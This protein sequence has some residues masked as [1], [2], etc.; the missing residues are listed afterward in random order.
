MSARIDIFRALKARYPV[1]FVATAEE[2]RLLDDLKAVWPG[3]VHS[4]TVTRGL[5]EKETSGPGSTV[6]GPDPILA[7]IHAA[8]AADTVFVLHD[9]HVFLSNPV[10]ARTL[11]DLCESTVRNDLGEPIP[12]LGGLGGRKVH[13]VVTCPGFDRVPAEVRC[14]EGIAF[15]SYNR[16]DREQL[17]GLAQLAL[18]NV[19]RSLGD[20]APEV[21]SED[22]ADALAGLTRGQARF[23]LALAMSEAGNGHVSPVTP[24]S[25]LPHKAALLSSSVPGLEI[26]VPDVTMADV[27]GL[28]ALAAWVQ[29]LAGCFGAEARAFGV[30]DPK[31]MLLVGI[32][33]CLHGD[34]PVHD[35]ADGTTRSV[36][37]RFEAREPFHVWA[38]GEDGPVVT[39]ALPPVRYDA[40]SFIEFTVEDGTSIR[41]TSRHRFWDGTGWVYASEVYERLHESGPVLLASSSGSDLQVRAAGGLRWSETTPGSLVDCRPVDRSDGGSPLPGA[42]GGGEVSPSRGGV[43]GRTP[44]RSRRGGQG[45]ATRRNPSCRSSGRPSTRGLRSQHIVQRSIARLEFGC[46]PAVRPQRRVQGSIEADRRR[47]EASVLTC[48]AAPL[49]GVDRPSTASSCAATRRVGDGTGW[50]RAKCGTSPRVLPAKVRRRRNRVATARSARETRA[51]VRDVPSRISLR[52]FRWF[53]ARSRSFARFLGRD[54]LRATVSRREP[55]RR[56]LV[57]APEGTSTSA[58]NRRVAS[59]TGFVK[60]VAARFVERTPYYD[61]HVPL[62]NNYWACGLWHHNC[63]KTLVAKALASAFGCTLFRWD[64]ATA[65]GSLVG[66]SE[67]NVRAAIAVIEAVGRSVVLLDE[68]EKAVSAGQVGSGGDSGTSSRVIGQ[69]L[70]WM[71]EQSCGAFVVATA[72]RPELLPTEMTRKGRFDETWAVDLPDAAGRGDIFVVHLRKRRRDPGTFNLARL[73]KASEGF[74][75]AEIE[76]VVVAALRRCFVEGRRS[77]ADADLLR[78]IEVTIPLSRSAAEDIEAMRSWARGK[79]RPASDRVQAGVGAVDANPFA[80]V[81]R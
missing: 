10:V 47:L 60:V 78:E 25:V 81:G 72:N 49:L 42:T 14:E 9:F 1:V 50:P 13:V 76:A 70:S 41:V 56:D 57:G 80:G 44:A 26:V 64:L 34:T 16:P 21:A 74:S 69:L 62:Y 27:A 43:R 38:M 24:A 46:R 59:P 77:L 68:V 55:T 8:V 28:G 7:K 40:Q 71:S 20:A 67:A 12:G 15:L 11:R 32:P 63:G 45:G 58:S 4:W 54:I 65:F 36:R 53:L 52:S 37:E 18:D 48:K 23:A 5:D 39:A 3:E 51:V 31:G 66:Q 73:A 19:G 35:P 30:P 29:T 22:V 79:A 6:G 61:F 33:G 75:G 2:R 17:A